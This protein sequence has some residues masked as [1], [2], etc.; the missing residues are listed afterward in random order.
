MH[1]FLV[2]QVIRRAFDNQ[3]VDRL[4]PHLKRFADDATVRI[5][6]RQEPSRTAVGKDA[7]A[8][9]FRRLHGTP[10]TGRAVNWA[11]RAELFNRFMID[12][13]LA[14]TREEH[15]VKSVAPKIRAPRGRQS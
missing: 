12:T 6:N 8:N 13:V 9:E 1:R 2:G 14:Q 7:I 4:E 10:F 11:E 3:S 5:H 15:L